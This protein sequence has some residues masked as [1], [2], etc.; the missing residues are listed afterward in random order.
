MNR[1]LGG[2]G[3]GG[4]PGGDAPQVDSSEQVYISSLA[5]LKMLKHG[6]GEG[7]RRREEGEGADGR[8]RAW[9]EM[10][11]GAHAPLPH[12]GAAARGFGPSSFL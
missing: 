1:L 4:G 7:A 6:E 8:E 5:L 9:A 10:E 3:G 11:G 12:A 2:L